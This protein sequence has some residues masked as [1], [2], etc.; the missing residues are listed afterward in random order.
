MGLGNPGREHRGSR[1]NVGFLVVAGLAERLR[2]RLSA[3]RGDFMSGRGSIAGKPVLLVTPLTYMNRSGLAV[4]RV[5]DEYDAFP[6]DLLVVCDDVDLPLGQLRLRAS[7]SDGGHR[8]L[9]SIVAATGTERFARLRCGVGRPPQET[10]TAEFVLDG[11]TPAEEEEA[12][13]MIENAVDAV[14]LAVTE[15]LGPA[16]TRFNRRIQRAEGPDA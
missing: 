12:G 8:G 6:D 14:H 15:G 3:G 5:L 10:D 4:S 9:A 1:H 11:F 7:G 16:M 13:S 2:I